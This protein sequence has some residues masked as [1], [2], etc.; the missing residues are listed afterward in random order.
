MDARLSDIIYC[1]HI[2][3]LAETIGML[4]RR[5]RQENP[6]R[7]RRKLSIGDRAEGQWAASARKSGRAL[8]RQAGGLAERWTASR[9]LVF[10]PSE[11][12][13]ADIVE[14]VNKIGTNL[15]RAFASGSLICEKAWFV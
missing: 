5:V 10:R 1:R 12:G 7:G 11:K 13:L 2:A 14:P 15:E 3:G 9:V 8:G 6:P 4:R